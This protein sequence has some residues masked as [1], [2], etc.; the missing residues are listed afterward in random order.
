[1]KTVVR[2]AL[3]ALLTGGVLECVAQAQPLAPPPLPQSKVQPVLDAAAKAGQFTYIVF[4]K[5]DSDAYR[6][7]LAVVKDGVAARGGK[8][9][10]TTADANSAGEQTLVETFGVG[11]APMPLTVAVA[12]NGAVTGV[13]AKSINDE[14]MAVAIVPPTMMRCMKS[15]QS[16]K[17]VFVCLTSDAATKAEVPAGVQ[18]VRLDPDFKDRVELV[19]MIANDPAESRFI[20][21]MKLDTARITGPYAVLI[22]PP[23]VLIGHY[24]AKSTKVEIAAAIHKAGQCC[25]DPNCKHNHAAPKASPAPKA[26]SAQR[27]TSARN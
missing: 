6:N 18:R 16:Q 3:L 15:L 1:M 27:P 7:M 11:R 2:F 26:P 23:G 25:D 20:R 12:P 13:F 17:L 21:E 5:G 9:T 19:S 24:D 22:A 14:Q 10:F 8:S 4:T